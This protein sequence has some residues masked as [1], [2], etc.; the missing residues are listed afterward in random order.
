MNE[1]PET[2][3]TDKFFNDQYG[4]VSDLLSSAYIYGIMLERELISAQ[5][6]LAEAR[7]ALEH[8][9][10]KAGMWELCQEAAINNEV[11]PQGVFLLTSSPITEQDIRWAEQ[12]ITEYNN[13]AN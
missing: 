11:I 4:G 9:R 2:P 5:A 7:R 8:L 6:E 13:A 1:Q 10:F 3:R 12:K